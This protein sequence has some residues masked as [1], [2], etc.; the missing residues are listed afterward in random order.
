M[1]LNDGG[2]ISDEEFNTQLEIHNQK[3]KWQENILWVRTKADKRLD[4]SGN[5]DDGD[6]SQY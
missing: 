6:Y 5:A 3:H 4:R 2:Q 1:S